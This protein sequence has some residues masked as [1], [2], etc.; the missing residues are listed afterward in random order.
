MVSLDPIAKTEQKSRLTLN[1][2]QLSKIWNDY[3]STG[4]GF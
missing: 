3:L 1:P 4:Y 2:R